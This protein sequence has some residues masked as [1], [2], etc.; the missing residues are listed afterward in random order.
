MPSMRR[1]ARFAGRPTFSPPGARPLPRWPGTP[2]TSATRAATC[3]RIP[4]ACSTPCRPN[5]LYEL[6][7]PEIGTPVVVDGKVF[8]S[9]DGEGGSLVYALPAS[10]GEFVCEPLWHGN[11][12]DA[13]SRSRHPPSRTGSSTPRDSRSMHTRGLRYGECAVP[14]DL[15][16]QREGL[17]VSRRGQRCRL[18]RIGRRAS[19]R[20][21]SGVPI[22]AGRR[23]NRSIAARESAASRSR[24][25][26]LLSPE[27]STTA[28]ARTSGRLR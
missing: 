16:W 13:R 10:C 9:A 24:A 5:W 14:S 8:V 1:T 20:I 26:R 17:L 2:S 11:T 23:A 12:V 7:A 3:S 25:L 6:D 21:Q 4:T 19:V 18:R 27:R 28:L 15:G 22:A